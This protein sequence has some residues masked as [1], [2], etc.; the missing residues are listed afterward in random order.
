MSGWEA[1]LLVQLKELSDLDLQTIRAT[2]QD[3]L[4]IYQLER[5]LEELASRPDSH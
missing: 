4:R 1:D 5:R 2:V 3:K